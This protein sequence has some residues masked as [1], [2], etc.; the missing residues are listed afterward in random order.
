MKLKTEDV[1][2]C[3]NL[4]VSTIKRWVRQGRIPIQKM[5][6]EC[7]FD[8]GAIEKWAREHDMAFSTLPGMEPEAPAPKAADLLEDLNVV[9]QRGGVTYQVAGQSVQEVVCNAV[10]RITAI[11]ESDQ[12]ALCTALMEREELTSTGIG[13]GIAIPHPRSPSD[14]WFQKPVVITSFLEAPIPY[15]AVDGQ[16]VFILFLL[17]SPTPKQHLHILSRLSFCVRDDSFVA[18]LRSCPEPQALL[19]RVAAFEAQLTKKG[20]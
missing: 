6:D 14:R 15:G 18:F 13:K 9:M 19:S 16:P 3:L 4:P 12:E 7:L 10:S 20:M 11:P 2:H 17:L 8:R 1:A 5:S